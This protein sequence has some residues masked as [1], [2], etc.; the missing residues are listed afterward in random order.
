MPIIKTVVNKRPHVNPPLIEGHVYRIVGG[1]YRVGC[2][3][4]YIRMMKPIIG[5]LKDSASKYA[6]GWDYAEQLA[7]YKAEYVDVDLVE[8]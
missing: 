3:F 4:Q 5:Y 8:P 7:T 6:G 2:Y 1:K